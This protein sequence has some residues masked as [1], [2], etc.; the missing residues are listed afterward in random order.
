M[1]VG[2]T[3]LEPNSC[4]L[5]AD[6]SKTELTIMKNGKAV[7][8]VPGQWVKIPQRAKVS[9]V[10]SDGDKVTQVQFSGAIKRSRFNNSQKREGPLIRPP[11]V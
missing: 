10:N 5:T 2:S 11:F 1:T 7:A 8:T 9:T 4:E 6:D 3:Q